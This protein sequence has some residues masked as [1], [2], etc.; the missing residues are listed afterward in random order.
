L[1]SAVIQR[2]HKIDALVHV[3]GGFAGGQPIAETS[4]DTWDRMMSMNVQSAFYILRAVIPR[5]IRADCRL[6]RLCCPGK[7]CSGAKGLMT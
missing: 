5:C 6:R 7:A 4:D 1:T 2:F 3:M